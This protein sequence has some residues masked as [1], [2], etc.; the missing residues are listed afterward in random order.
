MNAF[1]QGMKLRTITFGLAGLLAAIAGVA[2]ASEAKAADAVM[3]QFRYDPAAC[4]T[5][6]QGKIYIA[7]GRNVFAFPTTGIEVMT[8]LYGNQ[9]P[10]PPDPTDAE[11]C[12][13][14]PAQMAGYGFPYEYRMAGAKESAFAHGYAQADLLQLIS[15]GGKSE[16]VPASEPQ[17]RG[18][19]FELAL[20]QSICSKAGHPAALMDGA[21]VSREKLP[22]GFTACRLKQANTD[23]RIED[24]RAAYI[25]HSKTYETPSGKPFVINCGDPTDTDSV[26]GRC[27]VEYV[28]G[29]GLAVNYQ[30]HA[31][32]ST[33]ALP[34]DQVI[35]FDRG[36]RSAIA[37]TLVKNYQWPEQAAEAGD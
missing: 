32:D 20:A 26:G 10:T 17:W 27:D 8:A 13:A 34:I 5:D 35:A 37:A 21:S 3:H 2:V 36:L 23:S 25:A 24:M 9:G 33:R 22:N 30:F 4:K 31:S 15:I 16:T 18:E 29:S 14:H 12:P 11:G 28:L 1:R 7:L 6:A 19:S